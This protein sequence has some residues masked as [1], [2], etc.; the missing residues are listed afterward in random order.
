MG[1]GEAAALTKALKSSFSEEEEKRAAK[2][3]R[4]A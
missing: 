3:I 4:K 1:K 2:Q